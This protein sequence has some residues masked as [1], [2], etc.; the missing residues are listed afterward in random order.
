MMS[1]GTSIF[2][3]RE[4]P[5]HSAGRASRSEDDKQIEVVAELH[6][7]EE[8]D[9]DLAFREGMQT[10]SG[11]KKSETNNASYSERWQGRISRSIDVGTDIDPDKVEAK[12]NNG[13]LTVTLRRRPEAQSQR[14]RIAI[15]HDS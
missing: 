5:P 10:L 8:N 12:V 11:E 6:G 3:S 9:I 4:T 7:L 13:V 2:P 15:T 14:R 1:S